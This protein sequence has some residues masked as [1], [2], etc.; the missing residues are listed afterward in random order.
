MKGAVSTCRQF[1]PLSVLPSLL[2]LLAPELDSQGKCSPDEFPHDGGAP[3]SKGSASPVMV[4]AKVE[5][6]TF[7]SQIRIFLY[8][9][10]CFLLFF[11]S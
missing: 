1:A 10:Q 7:G 11:A 6:A 2:L 5:D 4:K 8:L 9:V 3:A